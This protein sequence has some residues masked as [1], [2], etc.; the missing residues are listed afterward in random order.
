MWGGG[1]VEKFTFILFEARP[2]K[3]E[4]PDDGGGA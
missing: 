4:Y 3:P 2:L 1:I